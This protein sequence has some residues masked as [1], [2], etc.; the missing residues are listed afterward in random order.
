MT[1]ATRPLAVL[2]GVA[3]LL[4]ACAQVPAGSTVQV[5]PGPGKGFDAFQADNTSCKQF[6]GQQVAGQA[7]QA[8]QRAFAIGLLNTQAAA[9]DNATA[10]TTIQQQYDTAF[11]QCMYSKGDEVAGFAPQVPVASTYQGGTDPMVRS[12]Q[13]E[14]IRLRYMGGRADG[15]MGANT[16]SA[17]GSFEAANGM[18]ADGLPS[19]QVLARLRATRSHTITASAPAR[20][21]APAAFVSPVPTGAAT[22]AP[23]GAAAPSAD[24][25][26]APVKTP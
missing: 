17:I 25:F 4:A 22:A 7:D 6:A 10:R 23:S 2:M 19:E 9:D 21:V 14:L 13:R 24:S 26:V 11:S 16:S 12:V 5:M 3:G 15:V 1:C 8:N 18:Q 20:A